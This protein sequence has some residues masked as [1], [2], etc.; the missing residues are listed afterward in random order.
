MESCHFGQRSEQSW[1]EVYKKCLSNHQFW[2]KIPW[3]KVCKNCASDQIQ[4]SEM[5]NIFSP[6]IG[7]QKYTFCT[8]LTTTVLTFGQNDSFPLYFKFKCHIII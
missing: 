1:S 4:W 2:A 8:L 6:K 7:G 3:S 5:T